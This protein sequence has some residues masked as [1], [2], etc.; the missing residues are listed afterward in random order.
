MDE[1]I[2][3][4]SELMFATKIIDVYLEKLIQITTAYKKIL[5]TIKTDSLHQSMIHHPIKELSQKINDIILLLNSLQDVLYKKT[6][7][8]LNKIDELDKFMY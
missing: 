7:Q 3:L 8:F 5:D 2:I 1:L 4:D 6:V